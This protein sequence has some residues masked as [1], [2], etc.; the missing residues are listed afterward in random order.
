MADE[1]DI[2][3]CDIITEELSLDADRVVVYD[4]NFK[5]PKDDA[6]Y[7]IIALQ[8]SK[9]IGSTNRY[10]PETDKEKK[11]VSLS[12]RYNVE[13]TSRNRTAQTRYPEIVAALTSTYSQQQ[14]EENQIK[15]FRAG[16]VL[17]L[18]FIEASSALHRYRIPVIINSVKTYEK[19]ITPFEYFP[20]PEED[21]ES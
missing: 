15:I 9:I 21:N 10:D 5:A 2:I 6:I 12:Q 7:V 18:S 13:I 4:Q 3:L 14:Q 11:C 20:D 16:D 1:P 8:Q 19:E 17:D